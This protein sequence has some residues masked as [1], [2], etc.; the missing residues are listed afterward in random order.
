MRSQAVGAVDTEKGWEKYPLVGVYGIGTCSSSL[1]VVQV[2]QQHRHP[3]AAWQV[4]RKEQGR[5][6]AEV[7]WIVVACWGGLVVGDGVD[8]DVAAEDVGV[9]SG[10]CL[11]KDCCRLD[12]GCLG[13]RSHCRSRD[14]AGQAIGSSSVDM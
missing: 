6:I 14:F 11:R 13:Q 10:N 1:V 3:R 8:G 12:D 5:G 7:Y 4:L 2:R 9:D